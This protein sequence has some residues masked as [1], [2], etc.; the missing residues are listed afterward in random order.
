[1]AWMCPQIPE[2]WEFHSIPKLGNSSCFSRATTR[3]R[4]FPSPPRQ[5]SRPNPWIQGTAA[6]LRLGV[7]VFPGGFSRL[8]RWMEQQEKPWID[9]RARISQG[10]AEWWNC[11]AWKTPSGSSS[12]SSSTGWSRGVCQGGKS[13]IREWRV[14]H[15]G[16]S[17]LPGRADPRNRR[18]PGVPGTGCGSWI[19]TEPVPNT[20]NPST[21]T[22]RGKSRF[23]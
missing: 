5:H 23:A 18:S 22:Q 16:C 8:S 19:L 7:R 2:A 3:S 1:M 11:S 21:R 6:S 9:P 13:G 20:T 15:P 17:R 14:P 4:S 10:I 12:P